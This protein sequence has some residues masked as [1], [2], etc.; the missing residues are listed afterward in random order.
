MKTSRLLFYL[1]AAVAAHADN[2]V[3]FSPASIVPAVPT[4][5]MTNRISL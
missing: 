4:Q 5:A 1:I 2:F 3:G